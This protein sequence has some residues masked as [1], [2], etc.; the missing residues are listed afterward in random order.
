MTKNKGGST[1]FVGVGI[2]GHSPAN[3]LDLLA[4]LLLCNVHDT[5][6]GL[7]QMIWDGWP[8]V[9]GHIKNYCFAGL[10]TEQ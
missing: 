10:V 3:S 7:K 8:F 5:Y 4:C 9:N 6:I 2:S 1:V